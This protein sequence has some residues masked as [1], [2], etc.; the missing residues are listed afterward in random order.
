MLGGTE[1][2]YAVNFFSPL[3]RGCQAHVRANSSFILSAQEM[4]HRCNL[5]R[6][7]Q[8]PAQ[9]AT[10]LCCL[11]GHCQWH[12]RFLRLQTVYLELCKKLNSPL[13]RRQTAV[14]ALWTFLWR[15]YWFPGAPARLAAPPCLCMGMREC[16]HAC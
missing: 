10:S 16:V 8:N 6:L 4:N 5:I 12:C 7:L 14:L 9:C 1:L 3:P 2:C 15:L 13:L 11:W